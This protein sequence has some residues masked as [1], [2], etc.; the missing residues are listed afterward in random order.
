[1]YMILYVTVANMLLHRSNAINIVQGDYM[2]AVSIISTME[3]IY[4]MSLSVCCGMVL[5]QKNFYVS[6]C[7]MPSLTKFLASYGKLYV[8]TTS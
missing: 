1:M 7:K 5:F 3:F 8:P 2:M 6:S 4:L